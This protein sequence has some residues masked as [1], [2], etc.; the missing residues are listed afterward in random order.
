MDN[1]KVFKSND[2]VNARYRL[3]PI[4]LKIVL[5]VVSHVE[6]TDTDFWTYTLRL[7]E[8]GFDHKDVKRA[9][10]SLITKVFEIEKPD[11]WLLSSWFSSIQYH[12]SS[13]TLS[14][15][16]DP[17]LKPYLLQL[18]EQ[19]T[20]YNL[21]SVLP[22]RSAYAI[23]LY[24]LLKQYES[25]GHRVID[26]GEFRSLLK[27]P[28]SYTWKDIRRQV[29]ETGVHDI[30]THS[31]ILVEYQPIKTGRKYTAV[32]FKI[33]SK[34]AKETLNEFV[35]RVRAN[36]VNMTL[37]VTKDKDT[38]KPVELS[39]SKDG[40]LYNKLDPDWHINKKRSMQ[41]WRQLKKSGTL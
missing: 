31:D 18:R 41:I 38:G 9:A 11:G 2:L 1:K 22:M 39:V 29:I 12:G 10:R 33:A 37:S 4:E 17:K 28:D 24:E 5:Y 13:G 19:F 8:L 25:I 40:L 35:D 15:Q 21:S 20:A 23:R 14:V 34:T 30:H 27:I 26:V 36:Y 32:S 3:T 6:S 7:S 16:F